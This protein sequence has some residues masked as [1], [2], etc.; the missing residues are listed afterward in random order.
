MAI[1]VSC[2]RCEEYGHVAAECQREPAETRQE[3][4]ERISRYLERWDA[5]Y[6][7]ITT[8]QKT[9]WIEDEIRMFPNGKAKAK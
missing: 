6:G 2:W 4:G 9:K 8:A 3:L 1:G 5:G 7:V